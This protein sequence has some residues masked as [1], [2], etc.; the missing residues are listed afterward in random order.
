[1][2]STLKIYILAILSFLVGTS[3]YVIAGILDKIAASTGVSLVTAGQLITVFSLAYAFGTP[4]VMVMTARM[5]RKK[6]LLFAIGFFV[7]S[8]ALAYVLPGIALLNA[9]RIL[10]G[11]SAGVVV[12]VSMTIATKVARPGKEG[13]ALAAVLMGFT[14]SLIFGVPLGRIMATA[15]EWK[16]VF[17]VIAVLGLAAIVLIALL[18]P[19]TEGEE[20]VSLRKQ[21]ALLKQP[22]ALTALSVT[23]FWIIGYSIFYSYITP[24][25]LTA[26]GMSDGTLNTILFVIGIASLIGSRSG[27]YATDKW[28]LHRVLIAGL[29]LNGLA[30]VL[31]AFGV[32]VPVLL[33]AML[34]LWSIA[35]WSLGPPQQLHVITIAPESTGVMLSLNS[36]VLQLAMAAGA[37]VGGLVVEQISLSAITWVAAAAIVVAFGAVQLSRRMSSR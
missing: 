16:A 8:N 18:I 12:V 36:M 32:H 4:L 22:R 26:V 5:E 20:V 7:L 9:S 30:L 29:A 35:V 28:G 15:Y 1:M 24:F 34:I 37:G 23:F 11:I 3:E 21:L 25:L 13:S 33:I 31:I 17:G 14:A 6:L 19:R 27:G 2:S 10:M